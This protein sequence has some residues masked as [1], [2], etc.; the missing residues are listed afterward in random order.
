MRFT[1]RAYEFGR[2]LASA[3]PAPIR[4]RVLSMKR[5]SAQTT[6]FHLPDHGLVYVKTPKVATGSVVAALTSFAAGEHAVDEQRA[7]EQ[8][9]AATARYQRGAF[10]PEI[11]RL[12]K[13]AFTF[14]FVRNPLDRLLSAYTH[15][16]RLR[17]VESK[18]I[19]VQHG[20]A[21]DATF[22]EF[23]ESIAELP[24]DS[25]NVHVRSQHKFVC[26]ADGPL[27]E[28]MGRFERLEDDWSV[29][30]SRFGLPGLPI[31]HAS[32]HRPYTESYTPALARLAADRYRRD[33]ELF[34]YA[35]DVSRLL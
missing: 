33:I 31:R 15:Q 7:I 26:D 28:Y 12:A 21:F 24:D 25:C 10:A 4:R 2:A 16:K 13:T 19:F 32:D 6:I 3:A 5:F 11:R 1:G 22:P 27:V 8:V 14:S 34:G 35:E 18:T 17:Q 20:I 9:A 30:Q 29:L 23:V